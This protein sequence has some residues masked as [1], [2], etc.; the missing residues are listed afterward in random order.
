MF[1]NGLCGFG[2]Q[3]SRWDVTWDQEQN[4]THR[5]QEKPKRVQTRP[6][7]FIKMFREGLELRH[8]LLLWRMRWLDG[9]PDSMNMNL[10]KLWEIV[11]DREAW[12]AAV[13]KAAKSWTW[14]GNRTTT[15]ALSMHTHT[16]THTHTAV[17][18]RYNFSLL[19]F[20]SKKF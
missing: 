13:H 8:M 5:E 9:I 3:N 16:H 15:V 17:G 6:E 20:V 7:E 14:L 10:G 12:C 18:C 19:I 4:G 2:E 1:T 11:R